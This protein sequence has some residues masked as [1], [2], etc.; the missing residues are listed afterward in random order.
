MSEPKFPPETL[1]EK[2]G[3][4]TCIALLTVVP[5]IFLIVCFGIAIHTA[6]TE[7]NSKTREHPAG[8]RES[9]V[10]E[11]GEYLYLQKVDEN[12]YKIVSETDSYDKKLEWSSEYY[13][14]YESSYYYNVWY[15]PSSKEWQY[16]DN[17]ISGNY[18]NYGW[19][20]CEDLGWVIEEDKNT[21]VRLPEEYDRNSIWHIT[22]E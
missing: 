19:M 13:S 4:Y 21:W 10:E 15:D 1:G 6:V 12:S 9:N 3:V 20:K 5:F 11:F 22:S 14:Y 16:W 8:Q 7:D 17:D 2:I 18:G